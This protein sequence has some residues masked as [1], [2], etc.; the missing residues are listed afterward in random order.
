MQLISQN[1]NIKWKLFSSGCRR[2]WTWNNKFSVILCCNPTQRKRTYGSQFLLRGTVVASVRPV[3]VRQASNKSHHKIDQ[4]SQILFWTA[5][6]E[7]HLHLT[8]Q[9]SMCSWRESSI[10]YHIYGE[11][12]G[13]QY[14]FKTKSLLRKTKCW[15]VVTER[16]S[17]KF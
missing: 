3:S 1:I 11:Q 6:S 16:N 2:N 9:I 15:K 13:S 14:N 12:S 5:P 17:T 8:P 7:F 4:D 10:E